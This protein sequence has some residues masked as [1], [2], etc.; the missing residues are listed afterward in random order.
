MSAI[1]TSLLEMKLDAERTANIS[2]NSLKFI[3]KNISEGKKKASR[4]CFSS[5]FFFLYCFYECSNEVTE[6]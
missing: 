4:Y 5:R 3:N 6:N 1:N 2:S